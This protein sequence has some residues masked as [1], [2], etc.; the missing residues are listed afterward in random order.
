MF[1]PAR[2]AVIL[3]M[4]AGLGS[5]ASGDTLKD[6]TEA[7]SNKD[8]ATAMRLLVPLADGGDPIAECMV[9]IMRDQAGG[10]VAYDVDDMSRTCIAA[11]SGKASAELDLAGDYR[12]GLILAQD[13]RRP[14]S[15]RSP[16]GRACRSRR[17][18]SATCMPKVW[19]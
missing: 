17:R 18:C 13:A 15:M 7:F 6:G 11:S 4:V 2:I 10:R 9:T 12:T 8:Y 16:P 5:A 1:F 3:A 19:A 14:S